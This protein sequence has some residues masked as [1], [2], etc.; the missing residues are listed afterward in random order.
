[1]SRSRIYRYIYDYLLESGEYERKTD[2]SDNN[3]LMHHLPL[4]PKSKKWDLQGVRGEKYQLKNHH[5]TFYET[6][7]KANP[8][9]SQFHYTA[10]FV[11]PDGKSYELHVFFDENDQLTTR[12]VFALRGSDDNKKTKQD[13]DATLEELM[14]QFAITNTMNFMSQLRTDHRKIQQDLLRRFIQLDEKL[15]A[16]SV[17]LSAKP[18]LYCT[19]LDET[20][21]VISQLSSYHEDRHFEPV[22]KLLQR[23]RKTVSTR[24]AAP[25]KSAMTEEASQEVVSAASKIPPVQSTPL[26]EMVS[27][28]P[29]I[30]SVDALLRLASEAHDAYRALNEDTVPASARLGAFQLFSQHIL[31]A[32][33]LLIDKSAP[34]TDEQLRTCHRFLME[35][36]NAGK[37]LLDRL[38]LKNEF[39]LALSLRR[40]LDPAPEHLVRMSLSTGNAKLLEFLHRKVVSPLILFL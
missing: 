15:Q 35:N 36:H 1:M 33:A 20:V 10:Y 29:M 23:I 14:I 32:N 30:F 34:E 3:Y 13:V 12:P 28:A 31:N 25:N 27:A 18:D 21:L 11:D 24:P 2:K 16:S 40:F 22:L 38:L 6:Q 37:K 9:L 19:A 7:H 39:P 4:P 17:D 8:F 5:L 26:P